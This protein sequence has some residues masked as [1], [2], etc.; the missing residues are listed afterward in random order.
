[1]PLIK[2]AAHFAF[3]YLIFKDHLK[4]IKYRLVIRA[5]GFGTLDQENSQTHL[6]FSSQ[7]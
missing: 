2:E 5:I 6:N 4:T 7:V 3:V 1:M